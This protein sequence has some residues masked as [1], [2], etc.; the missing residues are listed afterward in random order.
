M[1]HR[2]PGMDG[3]ETLKFSKVMEDNL[4]KDSVI[5][6]IVQCRGL[7]KTYGGKTALNHI[8]L[9]LELPRIFWDTYFAKSFFSDIFLHTSNSEL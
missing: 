5:I 4:C 8:N 9:N 3:I 1:D 2:M 7:T 6:A